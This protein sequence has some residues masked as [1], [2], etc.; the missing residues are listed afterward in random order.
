MCVCVF[1]QVVE[2]TF[3]KEEVDELC[4]TL[5]SKKN[6][7]PNETAVL[8]NKDAGRLWC[9][10]NFLCE[11]KYPLVLVLEEVRNT[12]LITHKQGHTQTYR[13]TYCSPASFCSFLFHLQYCSHYSL[14]K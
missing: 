6:Y 13:V 5:C 14:F 3:D 12:E 7:H 2:G 8:S 9:L 4:W 1:Y 11:D 10:F